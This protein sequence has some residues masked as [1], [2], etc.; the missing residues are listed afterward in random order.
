VSEGCE[1]GKNLIFVCWMSE[2]CRSRA[3]NCSWIQC[4]AAVRRQCLIVLLP[5]L[6]RVLVRDFLLDQERLDRL[7]LV[8]LELEDLLLGVLVLEHGAVAAMLLLDGLEDLLEVELLV[9]PSHCG[10][11]LATV[12][13]LDADV[14]DTLDETSGARLVGGGC[15]RERVCNRAMREET[16]QSP[17]SQRGGEKGQRR[18]QSLS[19]S[20][21][22]CVGRADSPKGAARFPMF[23]M[24]VVKLSYLR[25]GEERGA[26]PRR[27]DT[28]VG[29]HR[30]YQLSLLLMRQGPCG[31]LPTPFCGAHLP[32]NCSPSPTRSSTSLHLRHQAARTCS[33][34]TETC[35]SRAQDDDRE[36]SK[37]VFDSTEDRARNPR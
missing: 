24:Q 3:R 28:S 23:D 13:L 6:H 19:P 35:F 15:V 12:A 30:K 7:A 21:S 25:C 2:S 31:R 37:A 36:K 10:D 33:P 1:V 11:G 8:T 17:T 5:H 22:T 14:D 34:A 26:I 9:E 18:N 16:D 27:G 29:G 20:R 32:E 4:G